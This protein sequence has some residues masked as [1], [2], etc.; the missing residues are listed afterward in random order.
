M[1]QNA[2]S[3]QEQISKSNL[4]VND[5]YSYFY[6]HFYKRKTSVCTSHDQFFQLKTQKKK[7][8]KT[9]NSLSSKR[10]LLRP[11]KRTLSITRF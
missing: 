11:S 5:S 6:A 2:N 10:L 8:K 7:K 4:H 3:Y 1:R 9:A